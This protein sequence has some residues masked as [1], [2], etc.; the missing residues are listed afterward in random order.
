M[1]DEFVEAGMLDRFGFAIEDEHARL[2]A[3][4]QRLLRNQFFGQIV[5]EFGKPHLR[6][7]AIVIRARKRIARGSIRTLTKGSLFRPEPNPAIRAARNPAAEGLSPS[8]P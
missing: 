1:T 3:T 8:P 5:V 6:R 2:V 4:S 7:S